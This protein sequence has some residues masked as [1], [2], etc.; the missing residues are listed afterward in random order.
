MEMEEYA[1]VIDFLPDGR[2]SDREREPIA[3]L[4][5]EK[6]FTLLEVSIKRG[7]SCSLGQRLYIGK[8]LRE[9]VEKIKGR[10]DFNFLTGA[11]RNELP[12]VI[13]QIIADREPEFVNMFNKAGPISIRLHQL[14]LLPGIGKKHLKEIL[15]ARQEKPFESFKDLQSRVSLLPDPTNLIATRIIE[16]L[17]GSTKNYLFVRPPSKHEM[18]R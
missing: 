14:E 12:L 13:K 8:G 1:R 10:I 3:Q 5:G 17:Q 7:V 9:Q 4:V 11:A 6:Y 2:S 15:D 16:E 18:R